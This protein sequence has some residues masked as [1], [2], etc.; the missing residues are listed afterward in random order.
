MADKLDLTEIVAFARLIKEPVVKEPI[1]PLNCTDNCRCNAACGCDGKESCCELKCGCDG[2]EGGG[3][4]DGDERTVAIL[5]DPRYRTI[6]ESF[7]PTKVKTI[8]DFLKLAG[9]VRDLMKG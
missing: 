2:K 6:V 8:T 4:G 7:D 3:G 1:G 5:S 9:Q